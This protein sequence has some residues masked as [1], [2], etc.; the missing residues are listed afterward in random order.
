[1]SSVLIAKV[2]SLATVSMNR[3]EKRNALNLALW[4]DLHA[5]F[6]ELDRNDHLN[7]V[8]LK[9][10]G[11]HFAA[12][13]DLAEFAEE[14]ST[15]DQAEAYGRVMLAALYGIRDCRHPTIA[16][17]E[18]LCVGGGLELA[19]MCDL[20]IAAR[21][22]RFGVPIQKIGVV[23]PYP[24]LKMLT[25]ILGRPTM[26]ELLL[27]AQLHDCDWAVARGVI[28]RAAEDL[29]AEVAATVQRV[30]TGSPNSHALHKRFTWR[31][32]DPRALSSEELRESY[33]AVEASDYREGISAF[34]ERRKPDFG[35]R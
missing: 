30:S 22:A 5:V 11:G 9:G 1:M 3:P 4:R 21:D 31:A 7:C 8:V 16:A 18:G 23:M 35:K 6:T 27:E 26:L 2:G 24:E 28:H 29:S 33:A 13:A 20:R 32:L 19:L 25:Q 34:L 12:G 15:A 10:S 17:I 14:R